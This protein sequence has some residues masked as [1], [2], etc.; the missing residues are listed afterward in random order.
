MNDYEPRGLNKLLTSIDSLFVDGKEQKLKVK[1]AR[2]IKDNIFTDEI[3]TKLNQND[4][5]G[6]T[7]GEDADITSL[8]SSIFPIFVKKDNFIF[9][10]Y[11][12]KIEVDLSDEM[13]DR[14]IYMFSDGRLTSGIFQCF[15]ISDNEYVYGV[16]RIIDAVPLFKK[17]IIET[18]ENFQSN[19]NGRMKKINSSNTRKTA[20]K[21][22][23]E[24]VKYLGEKCQK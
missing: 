11:K 6:F 14:Y 20:E 15:N 22:Y 13:S 18:L 7:S 10:L 8:F 17:S 24:L 19:V 4:F 5:S 16:K 12:H 9:R 1:L 23:N 3:I 21:N 2:Q